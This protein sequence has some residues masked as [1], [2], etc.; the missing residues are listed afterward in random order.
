MAISRT[1]K[2]AILLNLQK[3]VINQ[4]SIVF[5]STFKADQ[6]LNSEL[7][8]KARKTAHGKGVAIKVIKN[9]LISHTFNNLPKLIGPT[10]VAY[11]LDSQNTNEVTVPKII[12]NLLEEEFN[13]YFTVIGSSV[14]GIFLDKATTSE[15]SKTPTLE[16]SISMIAGLLN[17]ITANIAISIKEVPS[18]TARSISEYSKQLA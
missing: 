1:Q 11:L 7:N 14:N 4:K 5:L 18:G 17:K 16:E 8:F 2:E 3:N 9:T 13:N 10:Y 15:L 12:V 6:N